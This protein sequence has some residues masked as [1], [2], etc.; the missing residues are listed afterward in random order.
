M[1]PDCNDIIENIA[2]C[3]ITMWSFFNVFQSQLPLFLAMLGMLVLHNIHSVS[4]M[5]CRPLIE[6]LTSICQ[7]QLSDDSLHSE[8]P[9]TQASLPRLSHEL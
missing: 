7:F 1:I 6:T 4:P 2:N 5:G 9:Q 8:E 3:D